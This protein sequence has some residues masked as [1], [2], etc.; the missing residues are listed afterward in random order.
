MAHTTTRI[1]LHECINYAAAYVGR[2]PGEPEEP[3]EGARNLMDG[4]Y[5]ELQLIMLQ[6]ESG[7]VLGSALCVFEYGGDPKADYDRVI[8]D[9]C[10]LDRSGKMRVFDHKIS[11]IKECDL[12][13]TLISYLL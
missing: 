2:V 13:A 12:E 5:P 11:P 7:R 3:F 4:E 8:S 9:V 10:L 1:N 6:N